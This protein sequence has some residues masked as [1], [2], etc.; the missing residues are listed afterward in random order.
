MTDPFLRSSQRNAPIILWKL[1]FTG[2][3]RVGMG[4]ADYKRDRDV[5]CLT[6]GVNNRF[7]SHLGCSG[8]NGNTFSHQGL[9]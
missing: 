3:A 9:V 5:F 2:S 6:W 8:Q 7:C 1:G 4:Y